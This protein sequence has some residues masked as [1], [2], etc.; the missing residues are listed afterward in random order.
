MAK[1]GFAEFLLWRAL[2]GTTLGARRTG[3]GLGQAKPAR[4]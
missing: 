4:G 1:F 3:R 2:A